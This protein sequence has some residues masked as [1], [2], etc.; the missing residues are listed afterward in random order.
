MLD[1]LRKKGERL[2]YK[3]KEKLTQD[4][5]MSPTLEAIM[6]LWALERINPGLPAKVQKLYGHQM[7]GDTCLV[8]LQPKIFKNITSMLQELDESEPRSSTHSLAAIEYGELG[9]SFSG[10]Y[11][12]NSGRESYQREQEDDL[13]DPGV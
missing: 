9:A 11:P 5:K 12:G 1:N 6:V 7:T 13:T 8:T 10:Y 2:E 3:N 4:E